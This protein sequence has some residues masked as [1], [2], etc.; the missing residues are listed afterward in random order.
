VVWR[1]YRDGQQ[2]VRQ[3]GAIMVP[4]GALDA[5]QQKPMVPNVSETYAMTRNTLLMLVG[6]LVLAV[7]LVVWAVK[8]L[9]S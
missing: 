1:V 4:S 9:R 2:P 6:G 3:A 7:T 5:D 8:R